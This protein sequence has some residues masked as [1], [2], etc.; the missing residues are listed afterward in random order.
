MKNC[1][2]TAHALLIVAL[3]L[4]CLL[5]CDDT[6]YNNAQVTE[7]DAATSGASASGDAQTDTGTTQAAPDAG[8][9][10][11]QPPPDDIGPD[12]TEVT[13]EDT[14]PSGGCAPQEA[15]EDPD[16][17]CDG[18]QLC[19][20]GTPWI[21]D[22]EHCRYEP[23]CCSCVG[24]DCGNLYSTYDACAADRAAC[25]DP[26]L[27]EPRYPEASLM[28]HQPAGVAGTGPLIHLYGDGTLLVWREVASNITATVPDVRLNVG[29]EEAGAL[30]DL[31]DGI[32]FSALPHDTQGWNECS[33][34]LRLQ[35]HSC[36]TSQ[37][38]EQ[39]FYDHPD[40]LRPEFN[41]VYRWF[42]GQLCGLGGSP[43]DFCV[44]P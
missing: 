10:T 33:V 35:L 22:G 6:T 29:A 4:S 8:A 17:D 12:A 5:G 15:G 20:G 19:G 44:W 16:I 11:A 3:A 39:L 7:D 37:C 24:A 27:T 36:P 13:V 43:S 2:P 41:R 23:I 26:N 1:H 42:E 40:A 38:G 31:L 32:D 21:W 14:S 18:C 25:L 30:F 34:D 28:W 9:D